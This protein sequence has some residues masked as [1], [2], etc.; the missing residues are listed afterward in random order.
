MFKIQLD[1][2]PNGGDTASF[3][4][5]DQKSLSAVLLLYNN[6]WSKMEA[7]AID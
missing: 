4:R 5:N 6:A 3:S 1:R 2:M 7:A